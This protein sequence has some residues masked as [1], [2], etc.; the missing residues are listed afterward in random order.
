M[1]RS[2]PLALAFVVLAPLGCVSSGDHEAVLK[3]LD[4][5]RL[6][7]TNEQD[8]RA[9]LERTLT[10]EQASRKELEQRIAKLEAEL[11]A[12]KAASASYSEEAKG[13]RSELATVVK[14]KSRLAASVDEMQVALGELKMRKA[15][16]DQRIAEFRGLLARF[17]GLIDAGKLHVKIVDGRMVVALATDVLFPSGSARLSKEGKEAIQEV[18]T[19]LKDIEGRGFQVEGHTDNVPISTAQYASNWELA[20]GRSLTVVKEMIEA[21]LPPDRVSA[22]SY[23]EYK[24]ATANETKEGKALNRRIEIVVVPDLSSLP[25][26]DELKRVSEN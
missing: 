1:K 16:A 13:L 14:D 8:Q 10:K 21:G 20:S 24:P 12:T 26:F 23:G 5:T 2:L 4:D 7:L 6:S 3:D 15:E 25:G 19:V 11:S 9:A 22:A 18:A 17:K